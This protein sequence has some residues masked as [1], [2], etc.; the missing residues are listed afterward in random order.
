[1]KYQQYIIGK[2]ITE[3]P[4]NWDLRVF[5]VQVEERDGKR[6]VCG[7]PIEIKDRYDDPGVEVIEYEGWDKPAEW[8]A[9]IV[10]PSGWQLL[11]QFPLPDNY[12]PESNEVREESRRRAVE[13][14]R[15]LGV[16]RD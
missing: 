9:Y 13:H 8:L 6:V 4:P 5:Y 14:L 10:P 2:C 16:W 3:E 15:K 7:E 12:V 1:M 11:A